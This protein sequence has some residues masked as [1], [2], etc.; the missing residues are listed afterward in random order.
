[1]RVPRRDFGLP[2]VD[3]F[4]GRFRVSG[5]Q[6]LRRFKDLGFKDLGFKDL[7]FKDLGSRWGA[8]FFLRYLWEDKVSQV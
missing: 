6:G 3:F 7:R 5:F 8:I 1:M 4:F 2:K